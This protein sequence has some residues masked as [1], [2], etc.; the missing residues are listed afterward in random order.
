MC[1][2]VC[3]CVC[4]CLKLTIYESKAEP[5]QVVCV[6]IFISL[7]SVPLLLS[8]PPAQH[9]STEHQIVTAA[10]AAQSLFRLEKRTQI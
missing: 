8:S 7:L 5:R 10:G 1:V 9:S 6:Q 4:V 2:C 3:V